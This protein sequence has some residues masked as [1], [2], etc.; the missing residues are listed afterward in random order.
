MK[1]KLKNT[2]MKLYIDDIRYGPDNTWTVART[3]N[4]AI[5][6]IDRFEFDEISID[7]DISHQVVVGKLSRPYPCN[8]TF[9]AVAYFIGQKYFGVEKLPK[10]T[11]HSSNP[12]GAKEM[13]DVL[14]QYGIEAEIKPT[15]I[16]ANRLE[17]EI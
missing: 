12:I 6:A 10:I 16:P 4:E 9:G 11:L 1:K 5:R 3:V 13:E 14:N 15:G 17:M 7:H 2:K 8:E